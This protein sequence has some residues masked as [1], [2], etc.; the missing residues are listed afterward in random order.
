P[1]RAPAGGRDTV[2]RREAMRNLLSV[3]LGL[4]LLA[5]SALAQLGERSSDTARPTRPVTIT[6]PRVPAARPVRASAILGAPVA[7]RAAEPAAR[8]RAAQ[9]AAGRAAAG[10]DGPAG[11]GAV[12]PRPAGRHRQPGGPPAARVMRPPRPG[13]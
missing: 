3:G 11:A 5:S 4:T 1:S 9:P 13:S 8:R 7:T 12:E 10:A 2:F 6:P